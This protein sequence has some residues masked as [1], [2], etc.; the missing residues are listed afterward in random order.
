MTNLTSKKHLHDRRAL[1]RENRRSPSEKYPLE[2]SPL[3]MLGGPRELAGL[4]QLSMDRIK[5][6]ARRPDYHCFE[7]AA[8]RPGK[9]P[10]YIQDPRGDTQTLQYRFAKFLNRIERPAFLHSA[11]R[12]RSHISNAQAHKGTDPVVCADIEKFY[13]NTTRAHVKD[14]L[15]HDLK[16]PMDLATTMAD[17]LTINQHLPTGSA[18][19]PILSYFTHR[20]M[21]DDIEVLCVDAGCTLTLFVDDITVSGPRASMSLLRSIKRRLLGRGLRAKSSK[22]KS[23]PAGSAVIITG[24][25]R[26]GDQLRIRNEHRK[27]IIALLAQYEAGAVGVEQSLQSKIAAAKC[28]DPSGATPLE[29]RF[30]RLRSAAIRTRTMAL[31]SAAP[32]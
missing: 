29:S 3:Y 18:V 6:I 21:F 30:I 17:A 14:F 28:V 31:Q 22:D 5:E 10:R 1:K 11:T 32:Q 12:G 8:S 26:D 23:A 25:V 20:R 2:R 24:A 27:G 19:S 13:E 9:A 15:L 4:M 16:W 7:E